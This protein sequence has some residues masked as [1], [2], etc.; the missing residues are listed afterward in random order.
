MTRINAGIPVVN[1]SDQHLLAE[2][3]EIKR[4]PRMTFKGV[5]PDKFT[6]GKGHVLFFSDKPLFTF[7]RYLSLYEECRRRGFS[8]E[9][10]G[11]NWGQ[12]YGE[13]FTPSFSDISLIRDRIIERAS[14]S[15]QVPRYYG[16]PISLQKYIELLS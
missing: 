6:L 4:I 11:D 13:Y 3:R 10:Y 5:V 9:Y 16:K 8:V 1:L 12:I 2:H 7:N 15:K 14:T